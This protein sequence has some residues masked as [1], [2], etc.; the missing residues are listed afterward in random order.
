MMDLKTIANPKSRYGS[1]KAATRHFMVQRLTG[2]L[3]V[4][5]MLF[6]IWLVVRLAGADRAHM[7][8]VIANP[9]VAILTALLLV[10]ITVHMRIGML[11]V[12]EDYVHDEKLNRLSLAL[13]TGFAVLIAGIGI[14]SIAKLVFWG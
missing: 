9:I 4:F 13:N 12:I 2:A 8:A 14:L 10:S 6:F 1:G 11:E 7:V 5:F 3:N